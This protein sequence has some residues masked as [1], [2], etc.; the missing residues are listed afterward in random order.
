[1]NGILEKLQSVHV[2]NR[3]RLSME[4]QRFCQTQQKLYDGTRNHFLSM[5]IDMEVLHK[6][7]LTFYSKIKEYKERVY[8]QELICMD[9][10]MQKEIMEKI[11]NHFIK[12]IVTFF[13]RKYGISMQI[14]SYERYIS[15]QKPIEPVV[16]GRIA[17]LTED[18]LQDYREKM[19]IYR[20]QKD[21]MDFEIIF[22]RMEYR[23][24]LDDIFSYLGGFSFQEKLEQEMKSNSKSGFTYAT[25]KVQSR[26]LSIKN[27]VYSKTDFSGEWEI[28]L[29]SEKYKAVLRALSFYDSGK[30]Q[31]EIYEGWKERYISFSYSGKKEKDGIFGEH[32]ILGKKVFKFKYF[33]NGRWDIIFDSGVHALEFAKEYLGYKGAA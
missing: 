13:N 1:M 27:L 23:L 21:K 28:M 6:Q 12:T 8:R 32:Q 9:K 20:K 19:D 17:S 11:H 16:R 24:I 4:D 18:E 26:T 31:I 15:I 7:E 5:F 3:T 29:D 10:K 33:K 2:Q 25:C 30:E 14:Y 22:F